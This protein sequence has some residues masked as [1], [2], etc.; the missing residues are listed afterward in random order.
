MNPDLSGSVNVHHVKLVYLHCTSGPSD[1]GPF[2][3]YL[4]SLF[5][6]SSHLP[7]P[8]LSQHQQC[9]VGAAP[10]QLP[11]KSAN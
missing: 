7:R 10:C 1:S 8:L 6:P 3:H 2:P 4:P 9:L 5:A 11:S